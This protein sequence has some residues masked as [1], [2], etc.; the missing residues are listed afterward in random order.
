MNENENLINDWVSAINSI[1]T[2]FVI[3]FIL[4]KNAAFQN[5]EYFVELFLLC[6]V[7]KYEISRGCEIDDSDDLVF[8]QVYFQR[9]KI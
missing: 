6:N 4:T 2:Q 1:I 7:V 3:S 9:A 5:T 8:L